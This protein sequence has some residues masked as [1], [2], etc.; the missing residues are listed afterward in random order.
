MEGE[1]YKILTGDRFHT[2]F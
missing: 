1:I 2:L